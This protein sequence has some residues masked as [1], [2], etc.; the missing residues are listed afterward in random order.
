MIPPSSDDVYLCTASSGYLPGEETK[1]QRSEEAL[2]P[3]GSVLC[4]EEARTLLSL[5]LQRT[6]SAYNSAWHH[7]LA[8]L[9]KCRLGVPYLKYL[10]PEVFQFSNVFYFDFGI[11]AESILLEHPQS[12][13]Q[14][15]K[16]SSERFLS[17]SC[18]C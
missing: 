7:A 6:L 15:L 8:S 5:C 14:H 16:C 3:H 11:F 4:E 13:F 1:A 9:T 17:G 2:P 18:W 12:D 10:E